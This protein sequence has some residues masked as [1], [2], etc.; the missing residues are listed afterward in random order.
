MSDPDNVVREGETLAS[1][2]GR[3]RP[4]AAVGFAGSR[5]GLTEAQKRALRDLLAE[6]RPREL[7]H[8]GEAGANEELLAIVGELTRGG[9]V[10]VPRVF[11]RPAAGGAS[12]AAAGDVILQ[13]RPRHERD[14]ALVAACGL[15]VACPPDAP[16][17]RGSRVWVLVR[18]ARRAGRPVRVV[19]PDGRVEPAP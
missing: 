1:A 5:R 3:G 14:L 7:H 17:R 19:W 11:C 13:P 4:G 12:T 16:E 15:L 2:A 6:L 9:A 8:G 18:R 10:E